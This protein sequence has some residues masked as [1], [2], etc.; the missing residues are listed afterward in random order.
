[1]KN[2][3]QKSVQHGLE[4]RNT[5]TLQTMWLEVPPLCNLFCSYCYANGGTVSLEQMENWLTRAQYFNILDQAAAMGVNSLGIPGAGEPFLPG[6][7]NS[8]LTI[9]MQLLR[10]SAE[11]GIF[12]TIFTTGE[13]ITEELADE[14]L[15]LPCELMIKGNSLNPAKQ[16]RFVSD[17]SRG[18]A[19]MRIGYG[20]TRNRALTLLMSKG[21]N[22]P[23]Y[24]RTSRMALVSSIMTDGNL[25]NVDELPGL[26]RFCRQNNVIFDCD[27]ILK[28]GRGS[29]C[30]LSAEDA[31]VK[32]ALETLQCIDKEEFGNSWEI[33]QSYVGTTCDRCF[34]HLYISHTGDIRPCIG[35]MDVSLGNIKDTALTEAWNSSVMQIFRARK[36]GGVCGTDCLN[37]EEGRCNSCIGRRSPEG[38]TALK[39]LQKGEIPTLGCW[40][41]RPKDN[42]PETGRQ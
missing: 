7:G 37:F 9:T 33:S 26:L 18:S 4:R 19:F 41:R 38:T 10:R 22:K 25:S 15:S 21:F 8:N 2:V 39:I 6:K 16:D 24:G 13:F 5:G 35:A 42:S 28:R 17:P 31:T 32:Q 20:E 27:T 14:L 11:L 1:M 3:S 23:G 34:H 29:S 30:G 36:F 12:V 40:N